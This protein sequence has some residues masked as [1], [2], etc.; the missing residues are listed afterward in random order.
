MTTKEAVKAGFLMRCADEGL[1]PAQAE[2]RAR[3][4]L[5]YVEKGASGPLSDTVNA[6]TGLGRFGLG[7]GVLGLAGGTALG[8]GGGYGLGSMQS[9]PLGDKELQTED[10]ANTYAR[11]AAK[12]RQDTELKKLLAEQ[13]GP[14][15]GI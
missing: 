12:I 2:L 10:M 13:K 5:D 15:R 6:A 11:L 3:K 14:R 9:D 4:I 8:F 1:T 7:L